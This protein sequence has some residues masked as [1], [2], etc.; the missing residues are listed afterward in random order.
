LREEQNLRVFENRVLRKV[1]G[2]TIREDRL[3]RRLHNDEL[4][5]LYSPPNIVTMIKSKRIRW[6]GYVTHMGKGEVFT[7]FW[8]GGPK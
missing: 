2:P 8:F 1:F 3:W 6:A 7:G 5:S 4:H